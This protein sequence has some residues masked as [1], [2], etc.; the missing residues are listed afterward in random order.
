MTDSASLCTRV[1]EIQS[2]LSELLRKAEWSALAGSL[3]SLSKTAEHAGRQNLCLQAQAL[4][5]LLG[6]RGGGRSVEPGP[7][8][9]EL[10][11]QLLSGLSHWSWN[12]D[13][14]AQ[15]QRSDRPSASVAENTGAP[16]LR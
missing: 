2:H 11:D 16:L 15:S 14:Q 5:E 4:S 12:L 6:D 13:E 7:R 8:V 10:M 1:R 3:E 9:Q